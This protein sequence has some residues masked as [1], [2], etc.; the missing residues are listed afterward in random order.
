MATSIIL[1]ALTTKRAE[2]SGLIADLEDRTRQAR[3]D[4][5]HL[6]ATLLLFDPDANL[7]QIKARKLRSRAGLFVTGEIS[8]RT[9]EA[10]R[11]ATAPLLASEIVQQVMIAKGLDPNDGPLRY[12]VTRSFWWCLY[13]MAKAGIFRKI[14][15]GAATRWALPEG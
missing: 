2:I 1:S 13:R 11:D 9:R 5:A 3:A 7:T 6:D 4:L 15:D 10:L 12:A 8:R 14:G